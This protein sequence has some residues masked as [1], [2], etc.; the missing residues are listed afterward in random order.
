MKFLCQLQILLTYIIGR[1]A[2]KII[3]ISVAR[4]IK[5]RFNFFHEI[6]NDII[7]YYEGIYDGIIMG[8]THTPGICI[9]DNFVH[10]NCGD[11]I[12]GHETYIENIDDKFYLK[13]YQ[14][15][16]ILDE[17]KI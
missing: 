17:M 4:L 8:H 16:K 13:S 14:D 5:K 15:G 1:K 12:D 9:H 11:W 6:K 3:R 10:I 2:Y 7:H